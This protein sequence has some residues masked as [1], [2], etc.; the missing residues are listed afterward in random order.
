M[1]MFMGI[2]AS[3]RREKLKKQIPRL[4]NNKI[5]AKLKNLKI[6]KYSHYG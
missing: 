5:N 4:N 1:R 3:S 2:F 6:H